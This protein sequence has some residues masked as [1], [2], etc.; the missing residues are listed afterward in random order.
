MSMAGGNQQK[1]ATAILLPDFPAGRS[2]SVG[3]RNPPSPPRM[4][5]DEIP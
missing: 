1:A 2:A 4:R 5:L 3:R